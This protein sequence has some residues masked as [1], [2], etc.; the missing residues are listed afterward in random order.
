MKRSLVRKL[1]TRI[2]R[3]ILYIIFITQEQ[4]T[5]ANNGKLGFIL[6]PKTYFGIFLVNWHLKKVFLNTYFLGCRLGM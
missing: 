4:E 5:S 1:L 6:R 2:L 3:P